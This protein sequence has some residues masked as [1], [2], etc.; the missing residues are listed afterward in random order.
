MTE[1]TT[2]DVHCECGE[3]TGQRCAW[4]G[5][6]TKTVVIEW[7]PAYLRESHRAAGN[8]GVYPHNG[9]L[10]LRVHPDCAALLAEDVM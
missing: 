9:A 3:A 8:A 7:M 5:P 6:R 2:Q 1:T 10:R 4:T